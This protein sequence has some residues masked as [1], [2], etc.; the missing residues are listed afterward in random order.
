MERGLILAD[1]ET[2][3]AVFDSRNQKASLESTC[4]LIGAYLVE[5][6]ARKLLI[7]KLSDELNCKSR[8]IEDRLKSILKNDTLIQI[9]GSTYKHLFKKTENREI[10]YYLADNQD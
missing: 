1:N 3:Q 4:E 5:P 6:M 8:T 7:E 10:I 2:K 9:D